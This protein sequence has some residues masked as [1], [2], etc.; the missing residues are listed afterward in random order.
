MQSFKN[1]LTNKKFS[2]FLLVKRFL[3]DCLFSSVYACIYIC[4]CVCV[5]T[6]VVCVCKDSVDT[7]S[8]VLSNRK[9][10]ICTIISSVFVL[11]IPLAGN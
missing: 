6:C 1:C 7:G 5:G 11:M 8:A 10:L 3:N 2:N 4:V 9:F